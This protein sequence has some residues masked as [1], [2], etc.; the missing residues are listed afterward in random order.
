MTEQLQDF[1]I[2]SFNVP[3]NKD[4]DTEI[5]GRLSGDATNSLSH[6]LRNFYDMPDFMLSL[7]TENGKEIML[8]K[9]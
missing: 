3:G 4:G 9:Q 6:L 8:K 7:Y 5:Q 2:I 1:C